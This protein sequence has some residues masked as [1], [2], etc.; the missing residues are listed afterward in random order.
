MVTAA[1]GGA[2]T[3]ARIEVHVSQFHRGERDAAYAAQAMIAVTLRELDRTSDWNSVLA[4]ITHAAFVDGSNTLPRQ[5]PDGGTVMVCCGVGSMT[6]RTRASSA[7]VWEPYAWQSVRV[8]LN[9]Q[10]APRQYVVSWT[11]DDPDDA[12]GDAHADSNGRLLVRAE[13][14]SPLGLRKGHELLVERAP[15]DPVTGVRPPGLRLLSWHEVP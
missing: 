6:A 15:L 1:A 3:L 10:D 13:A 9:V 12:D 7:I 8:L 4:G 14:A 11:A 5:I 2:A